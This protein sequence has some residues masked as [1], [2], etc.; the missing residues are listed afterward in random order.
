MYNVYVSIL[1]VGI[2]SGIGLWFRSVLALIN[3]GA[4]PL[5]RLSPDASYGGV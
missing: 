4:A 5:K 1:I 2:R 3:F